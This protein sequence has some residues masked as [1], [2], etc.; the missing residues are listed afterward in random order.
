MS[1][2]FGGADYRHCHLALTSLAHY[3]VYDLSIVTMYYFCKKLCFSIQ[4]L[5]I[6]KAKEMKWELF[7]NK[8]N[9]SL[10]IVTK[11]CL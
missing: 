9:S 7:F 5:Q 11:N 4:R 8:V 10:F 3:H 2:K 6:A 1:D